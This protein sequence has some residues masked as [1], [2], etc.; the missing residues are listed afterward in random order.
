MCGAVTIQRTVIVWDLM[1]IKK[2]NNSPGALLLCDST[3]G[4][5]VHTCPS[6]KRHLHQL[7][8][9]LHALSKG[10]SGSHLSIKT[11]LA[12][13]KTCADVSVF[14][15]LL[16]AGVFTLMVAIGGLIHAMSTA[17]RAVHM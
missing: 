12:E 10:W 8:E 6:L 7:Q 9:W 15:C 11:H 3:A 17:Q 13:Q 4:F 2:D 1:G 14:R 5:L 16:G